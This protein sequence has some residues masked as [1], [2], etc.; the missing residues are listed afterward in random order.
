MTQDRMERYMR[1]ALEEARLAGE[2]GDVPV[3]AGPG[4]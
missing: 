4:P 3:G 2:A 1:I